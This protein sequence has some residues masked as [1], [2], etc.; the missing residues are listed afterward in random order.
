MTVKQDVTLIQLNVQGKKLALNIDN[1]KYYFLNDYTINKL[2]EGL[3][4]ENAVVQYKGQEAGE[5]VQASA[6]DAEYISNI[7]SVKI[8]KL[9]GRKY[10]TKY[11]KTRW[12]VLQV[13]SYYQ[14]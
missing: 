6:S 12:W 13:L 7:V 8:L 1:G 11:N 5:N 2:M 3:I 10:K 4:D 14:I 9:F